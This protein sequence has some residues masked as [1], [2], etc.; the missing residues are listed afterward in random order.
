MHR[1]T[2]FI[3]VFNLTLAKSVLFFCAFVQ[4]LQCI[5]IGC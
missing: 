1:A 4:I 2:F 5:F 3:S